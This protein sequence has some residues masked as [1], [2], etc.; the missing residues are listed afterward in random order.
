MM[1]KQTNQPENA[2]SEIVAKLLR[3]CSLLSVKSLFTRASP[4][5]FYGAWVPLVTPQ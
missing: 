4:V 2:G 3:G 5:H 1:F